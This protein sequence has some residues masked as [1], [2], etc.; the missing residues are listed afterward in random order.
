[1]DWWILGGFWV[2]GVGVDVGV[3]AGD[4]V[5]VGVM[6]MW[7]WEGGCAWVGVTGRVWAGDCLLIQF[8]M[9]HKTDL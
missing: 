3:D 1:M 6:L 5:G 2:L 9:I 4:E 7:V 8:R